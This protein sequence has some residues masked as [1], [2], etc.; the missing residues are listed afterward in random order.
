MESL[1]AAATPARLV[2]TRAQNDSSSGREN[3]PISARPR[4]VAS[5]CTR[6]S[7]PGRVNGPD[8]DAQRCFVIHATANSTKSLALISWLL[9]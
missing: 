6:T 2:R 1:L 5:P 9:A 7:V 8:Y 4:R 3:A